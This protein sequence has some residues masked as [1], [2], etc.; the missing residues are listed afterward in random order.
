MHLI[1]FFLLLAT[2]LFATLEADPVFTPPAQEEY[3]P[4][5]KKSKP[6]ATLSDYIF[7]AVDLLIWDSEEEGLEFVYKNKN[8]Q[9]NQSLTSYKPKSKFDPAFRASLGGFLPYDEWS[10][11]AVYTY[12]STERNRTVSTSFNPTAAPGPGLIAVWTYPAAFYNNNT[13]ARFEKAKNSWDMHV[14]FLDL[15][16]E[17][18]CKVGSQFAIT[19]EFG[20]RSAWIHQ[21]YTVNYSQGNVI[22]P[23]AGS[24]ITVLSSAIDMNCLSNNVGPLFGL[25]TSWTLLKGL[26]FFANFSTSLLASRF[27]LGRGETD[28][29]TTSGT[30]YT[31]S[32]DLSEKYWTFRPQADL[33]IG[34]S[35]NIHLSPIDY[36]VS[37]AYET[38]N[39]WKQN[40]LL[41]YID[42]LNATS[43]GA[44]V[45][46]TQ[47]NLMFHGLT[48]ETGI[49]Y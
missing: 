2:S 39:W 44:Y 33:S 38:Q 42:E 6:L 19:P 10:L 25:K 12:Y 26:N 5:P 24:P 1:L 7:F 15:S 30:T 45:S 9:I 47:G 34:F 48:L 4:S 14:S 20:I 31:E 23:N 43:G 18:E 37:G 46:Q 13:A 22:T 8:S 21:R 17:R 32:I 3:L 40:G 27:H 28:R 35:F 36:F 49:R 16:L 41:R 29:Y 11:G